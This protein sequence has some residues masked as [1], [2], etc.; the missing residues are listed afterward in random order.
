MAANKNIEAGSDDSNFLE[1]TTQIV[2][3]F[4]GK[5]AVGASDLPS[6]IAT[7]HDCLVGLEVS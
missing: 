2:S 3:A 4:V 5:N 6:L 7:V 1:L